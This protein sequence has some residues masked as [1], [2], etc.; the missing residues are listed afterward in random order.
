MA[1][2][3]NRFLVATEAVLAQARALVLAAAEAENQKIIQALHPSSDQ[4]V[5]DGV[6]NAQDSAFKL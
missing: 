1:N 6:V 5:I 4:R 3:P 2:D